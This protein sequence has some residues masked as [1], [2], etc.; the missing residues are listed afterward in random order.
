M[1]KLITRKE[2]LTICKDIQ[3]KTEKERYGVCKKPRKRYFWE[4]EHG[5]SVLRIN[6]KCRIIVNPSWRGG[7][8]IDLLFDDSDISSCSI[9]ECIDGLKRARNKAQKFIEMFANFYNDQED[10]L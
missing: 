8:D 2:A 5:N 1:S 4:K 6:E 10:D 7:F 9:G 3:D